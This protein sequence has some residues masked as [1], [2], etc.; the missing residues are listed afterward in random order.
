M[1]SPEASVEARENA[2][3]VLERAEGAI[4]SV[5]PVIITWGVRVQGAGLRASSCGLRVSGF[6]YLVSGFGFDGP[7]FRV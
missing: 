7:G 3:K 5:A 6:G 1:G 4:S 2:E